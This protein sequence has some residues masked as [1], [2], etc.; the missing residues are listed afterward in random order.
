VAGKGAAQSLTA[1]LQR[2]KATCI[3]FHTIADRNAHRPY[4]PRADPSGMLSQEPTS[5]GAV[6]DVADW[7]V[8]SADTQPSFYPLLLVAVLLCVIGGF[9][10]LVWRIKPLVQEWIAAWR[11]EQAL[12]RAHADERL[13]AIREDAQGDNAAQR[14]LAKVQQQAIVERIGER[15]DRVSGAVEKLTD[16]TERHGAVLA[17]IA[18]KIGATVLALAILL[19]ASASVGY[20]VILKLAAMPTTVAAACSPACN[21]GFYCCADRDHPNRCCE[22]NKG[23][24]KPTPQPSGDRATASTSVPHSGIAFVSLAAHADRC[25]NR[26][27]E[28]CL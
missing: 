26:S 5:V 19:T 17:S 8:K 13:K 15:V 24:A 14:E 23:T 12:N 9:G 20:V 25:C 18:A 10:L 4:T 2:C 7:A 6:R 11:A 1:R 3:A 28:V 21:K 16:R 27:E 22:E